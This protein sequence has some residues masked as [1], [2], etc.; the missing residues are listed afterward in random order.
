MSQDNPLAAVLSAICGL[1]GDIAGLHAVCL[2]GCLCSLLQDGKAV[3]MSWVLLQ[4]RLVTCRQTAALQQRMV[5]MG[6]AADGPSYEE[7]AV[8]A[9]GVIATP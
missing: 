8:M 5:D 7:S 3:K 6:I 2:T 9:S 4:K 1:R